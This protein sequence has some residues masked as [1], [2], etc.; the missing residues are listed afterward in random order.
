MTAYGTPQP[1]IDVY[2]Y[3]AKYGLLEQLLYVTTDSAGRFAFAGLPPNAYSLGIRD[4][5]ASWLPPSYRADSPGNGH[6]G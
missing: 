5:P 1:A 3:Q 4:P 6:Q 2:L